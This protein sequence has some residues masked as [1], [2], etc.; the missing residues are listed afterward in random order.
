MSQPNSTDA[1]LSSKDSAT[2]R[3]EADSRHGPKGWAWPVGEK[4][5]PF[6][7]TPIPPRILTSQDC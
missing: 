4:W 7:T 2:P 1:A 6:W 5:Y 3:L